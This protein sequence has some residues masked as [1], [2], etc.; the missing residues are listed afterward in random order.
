MTLSPK[1]FGGE[2]I[3]SAAQETAPGFDE[4]LTM[5]M[6]SIGKAHGRG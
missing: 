6:Q 3:L 4:P 5:S 2:S 1:S